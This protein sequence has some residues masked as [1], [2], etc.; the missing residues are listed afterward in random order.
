MVMTGTPIVCSEQSQGTRMNHKATNLSTLLTH[1][2]PLRPVQRLINMLPQSIK[3][4]AVV[5]TL[6][7]H[8][9]PKRPDL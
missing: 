4:N 8:F 7:F 5:H 2:K 6:L 3:T 1:K 9:H